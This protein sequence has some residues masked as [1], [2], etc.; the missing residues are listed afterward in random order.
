MR[1]PLLDVNRQNLPLEGEFLESLRRVLH[2]GQYILGPEVT[3]FEAAAAAVAGAQFGIGM[4]SGTDAILVA[5]MALGIG[6]G[7]EVIC[8]AFTFFATAGCIARVGAKPVFADSC[9][10]CFNLD[11]AGLEPLITPRTKAII[12]VHLFGQAAD[13]DAILAVAR[14]HGLAVIEDAAQSF[15]AAYKGRPIG[16]MGDFGTISFYP[17]KN[18]G[19]LGDAGLLVTNDAELAAKAR[20]LRE[21]GAQERYYHHMVG[22]NF[23][24]DAVQAAF[25]NIKLPHL[26]EYT[27]ARQRHAREYTKLLANRP[28]GG[29]LQIVPPVTHPDRTHIANQYTVRVRR[30][31]EWNGD[32]GPASESP[33]DALGRF[34]A[35][36]EIASAI[37]YPLPLHR[38]ECF[39]QF[40]PYAPLPV[41]E[42]LADEVISLPVFPELTSEEQQTVVEAIMDFDRSP[43][44]L[45]KEQRI[46]RSVTCHQPTI[47]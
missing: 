44:A 7:D 10:D 46:R 4:S 6:P 13:M 1:I 8:P 45:N 15:G 42:S 34:L 33:R 17:S 18:L 29:R 38:Q 36:R 11:P 2:S 32:C 3:R 14:N 30:G 16:S 24:L 9:P 35:G 41:A 25:L 31:H 39:R 23:R 47:A 27:A 40:G 28:D 43:A 20:L 26:G 37:Y 21:H 5:L 22:G 19:A 12:P